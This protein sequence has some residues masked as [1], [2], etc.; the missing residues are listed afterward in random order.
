MADRRRGRA[1]GRVP[2]P[3]GRHPR[4]VAL[5]LRRLRNR[6]S[7]RHTFPPQQHKA[8]A[9][10]RARPEH[11]ARYAAD[12]RY[13]PFRYSRGDHSNFG[14]VFPWWDRLH[15]TLRLNIPQPQV[16]IGIPGYSRPEDNTVVSALALPFRQQRDY[17]Q[18]RL[19]R[20]PSFQSPGS[21][22]NHLKS[23]T[24]PR[25]HRQLGRL[26]SPQLSRSDLLGLAG[27]G[28]GGE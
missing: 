21:L 10:W 4:A 19:R 25:R 9:V 12:A 3:S 18:D 1:L 11:A 16:V 27:T 2:Q 14:V 17:W 8:T 6:V 20:R 15:R 5:R 23:I 28:P 26:W 24:K 13:P 22:R 7:A